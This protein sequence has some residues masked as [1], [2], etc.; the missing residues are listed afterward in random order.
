MK[1]ILTIT[2]LLLMVFYVPV[3]AHAGC[4][5]VN[6]PN[7]GESWVLGSTQNITWTNT[8]GKTVKLILRKGGLKV[9]NIATS[10]PASQTAYSWHVGDYQGGTAGTGTNYKIVIKTMDG[11]ESD[12]SN[13]Y[14][15]I[16]LLEIVTDIKPQVVRWPV[17]LKMENIFSDSCPYGPDLSGVDAF[18]AGNIK[19]HLKNLSS[20]EI[21]ESRV[22]IAFYDLVK[23]KNEVVTRNV[24]AIPPGE[25]MI[26]EIVSTPLLI[27]KSS[28][29]R[30]AAIPLGLY[31]D[32][33][34]GNNNIGV[35]RCNTRISD[36][37]GV[38]E[39]L[40]DSIM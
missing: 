9:G 26:V 20:R 34:M 30:G 14:F 16:I 25:E 4:L 13:T 40:L 11:S 5:T 21:R 35:I 24:K 10:L 12:A 38:L 22:R 23:Q 33:N 19:V 17:D 39:N 18:Y 1:I 37:G 7:G 31:T 28:G 3:P 27:R 15:S 8:C 2:I 29:I 36:G 32:T 6:S